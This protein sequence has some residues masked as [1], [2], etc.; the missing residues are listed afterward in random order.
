MNSK[1]SQ[2]PLRWAVSLHQPK[3]AL[4]YLLPVSAAFLPMDRSSSNS[5]VIYLV[6]MGC[7]PSVR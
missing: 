3:C 1:S 4:H 5:F 7:F 2:V 6:A